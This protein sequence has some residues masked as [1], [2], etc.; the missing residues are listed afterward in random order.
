M[1][2]WHA[3]TLEERD[4]D[5]ND[6]VAGVIWS[7][8]WQLR[9]SQ[10]RRKTQTV[11][12]PGDGPEAPPMRALIDPGTGLPVSANDLRARSYAD[13][14]QDYMFTAIVPPAQLA[15]AATYVWSEEHGGQDKRMAIA[16]I[17]RDNWTVEM[18]AAYKENVRRIK[19]RV[20]QLSE[21]G[22]FNLRPINPRDT[23]MND[24]DWVG[25]DRQTIGFAITYDGWMHCQEWIS[26]NPAWDHRV[27]ILDVCGE[28]VA[29]NAPE[30]LKQERKVPTFSV[31][32][33]GFT[34]N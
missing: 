22:Y 5:P 20:H 15:R 2:Q 25:D 12:E 34:I 7:F 6:E 33:G 29:K 18:T 3:H 19:R 11:T 31:Q 32:S 30:W 14:G 17:H 8:Y 4:N 28:E 27:H 24:L 21:R 1:A 10:D 13:D 16:Y 23:E 26:K 9:H